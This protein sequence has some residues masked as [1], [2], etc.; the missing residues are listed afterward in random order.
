M[1]SPENSRLLAKKRLIALYK[2]DYF[3]VDMIEKIKNDNEVTDFIKN[4]K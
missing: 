3:V 4:Y 1:L 2:R